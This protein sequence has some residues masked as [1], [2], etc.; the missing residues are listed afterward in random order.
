[1]FVQAIQTST[2]CFYR[3]Y[4]EC[5]RQLHKW[6]S[7]SSKYV[8]WSYLMDRKLWYTFMH[9]IRMLFYDC[10]LFLDQLQ[11]FCVICSALDRYPALGYIRHYHNASPRSL[12]HP[13]PR[14]HI[15]YSIRIPFFG[16]TC[17]FIVWIRSPPK[18]TCGSINIGLD[19]SDGAIPASAQ[20]PPL[21]DLRIPDFP[22]SSAQF[23]VI[24]KA[25][26]LIIVVSLPPDITSTYRNGLVCMMGPFH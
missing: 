25:L 26:L 15:A 12:M 23:W 14:L 24:I 6:L 1:M 2:T 22:R 20:A 10:L 8:M 17:H 16:H 9:D 13:K 21:S 19:S 3:Q 7:Y 11:A 18:L 5:L 4:S